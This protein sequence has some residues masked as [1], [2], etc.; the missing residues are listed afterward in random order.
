MKVYNYMKGE[1]EMKK[2]EIPEL[3]VEEL[4]TDVIM[5]SGGEEDNPNIEDMTDLMWYGFEKFIRNKY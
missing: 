4:E 5:T 1:Q 2:F 3:N